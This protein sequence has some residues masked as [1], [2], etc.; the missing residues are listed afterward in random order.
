MK[1][2]PAK[3]FEWLYPFG[4][5]LVRFQEELRQALSRL[6]S[7]ELAAVIEACKQV[8]ESNCWWAIY[9]AAPFVQRVAQEVLATK[10]LPGKSGAHEGTGEE[11][12]RR[13]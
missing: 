5:L 2:Q 8:T 10:S 1:K 11:R 6:S 13:G 9:E 12:D 3:T 7:E 4:D